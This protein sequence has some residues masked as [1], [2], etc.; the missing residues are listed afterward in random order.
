MRALQT[1]EIKLRRL[2]RKEAN[3]GAE[4]RLKL[5][6]GLKRDGGR[7]REHEQER[8]GGYTITT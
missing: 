5:V 1:N 4:V 8:G 2:L 7:K 6:N 3:H